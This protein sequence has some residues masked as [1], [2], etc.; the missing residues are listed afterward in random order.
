MQVDKFKSEGILMLDPLTSSQVDDV[1]TYLKSKPVFCGR[2]VVQGDTKFST[3]DEAK[4]SNVL[5]WKLGDVVTAP[6]LLE[7]ALATIDFAAEYLGTP[8]PYL[9]SMNIFV[10]RP[11]QAVRP[12]IQDWHRDTDDKKFL[13]MFFYL[14]D[15]GPD[16]RQELRVDD[17]VCAIEGPRGTTFF[18][19]TMREHR[20]LK[21]QH[22]E[23]IIG[24]ARWGVSNPPPS[25][26]WD[27]LSAIPA[28]ALGDRYPIAARLQESLKLLVTP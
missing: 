4:A 21:P 13:P 18:S 12:D 9:Y 24:W 23:R 26:T 7:R 15:V 27:K 6:H 28:A 2:H 5:C 1:L 14:T 19:D 25:Y 11:G 3:W 17:R 22:T 20:G 16:A 10:T 8:T